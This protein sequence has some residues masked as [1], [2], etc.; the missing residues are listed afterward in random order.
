MQITAAVAEKQ[1]ANLSIRDVELDDHLKADEIL[2]KTV[3]S[4]IC[5]MDILESNGGPTG[6]S[7]IPMIL[8]HEGA[9]IVQKVGASVSEFKP[10]DHVTVSYASCGTCK[11]CVLGH[12]YACE[13]M[14]ELTFGGKD[15]DGGMRYSM[16]GKPLSSFFQQSSFGS[17]MK[18]QARNVAKVDDSVDLKLLGPLGCGLQT[19]AGTVLNELDPQPGDGIIVFGTG[20]VGL[21]AIMAAKI[22]HCDPIIAVDV[23]DNR[24]ELAQ[25]LGA[26][27]VINS[28]STSDVPA[29]VQ[30]IAAGGVDYAVVAAGVNGL[31]EEAVRSVGIFGTVAIIGGALKGEFNMAFDFL[32]FEHTV[33]GVLQGSSLP[34]IFIPKLIHLFKQGQFPFDKLVKFYDLDQVNQAFED[35]KNGKVVKPILVM[36]E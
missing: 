24:L 22:A 13:R 32:A 28:K 20:T 5:S 16:D 26:T 2:V 36:P 1:G 9:G 19:G 15:I 29:E 8:G 14:N 6:Q 17:Y 33:K 34:K 10:G 25:E 23:F 30:K 12:P 3:A 31:A 7:P 4:G 11:Q 21:A 35:S 27:N 18:V